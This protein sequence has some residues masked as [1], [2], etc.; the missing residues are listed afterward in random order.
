M[1]T[2]YHIKEITKYLHEI[3]KS[4]EMRVP[5]RIYG[6]KGTIRSLIKDVE[7]GKEW[8][9][10]KQ[11]VNVACLPGIIKA[12]LAMADVHPGYG[13]CIGGVG[14]FD[15]KDG[16]ISV[17]GVGFDINCGVRTLRTPLTRKKIESW[18]EEIAHALYETVPAGLGSRGKIHLS[19]K[20]IDE[21]LVKGARF[22]VE[23]GYG[24]EEDLR[25]IENGGQMRDADPANVSHKAKDRQ[26]KQIGTLGSGNHYLEIQF[27][28]EIYDQEAAEAYGLYPDQVLISIHSGS[29]A[30]GHQIGTDYLQVLEKA[31]KKY[32]IPIREREL[33]CAP[34][35]SDEGRK[36][37][38]AMNAGANCA[39]ANR[40]AMA[41]LARQAF[42]DV[43]GIAPGEIKTFYE[44]AHNMAKFETHEVDG[45]KVELLIHRK[46]STRAFGPGRKELPEEYREVGQPV[47]VG[48]TMGTSSYILRGTTKGME[49]A[50]GS[51]I[52]GAGRHMSRRQAKKKWRGDKIVRELAHQ[53]ILIMAHSKPGVAEEA[54]LAYKDVTNV[55]EIMDRAG[56]NKMVAK[57]KPMVCIKG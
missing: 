23:R 38:T 51:A 14:A 17:A 29:R 10:L 36:Y 8:N 2:G 40:Q 27:V 21:V 53:G 20:E 34:I 50:F 45:K 37:Y 1:T 16:V 28:D 18:K 56:I 41:H 5:G 32:G 35:K 12:S 3:P 49:E 55:T 31:S 57:L 6:D 4:G 33:V 19:M 7:Q 54:P 15:L 43:L 30:L 25:F 26:Q 22:S 44:V 46:G 9:A 48:G 24:L 11:I 42:N 47:L 52:H 13:F 39:F